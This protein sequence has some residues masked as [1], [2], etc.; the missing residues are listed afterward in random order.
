VDEVF[1]H[2]GCKVTTNGSWRRICRV[3]LSHHGAHDAEHIIWAFND[4]GKQGA[5]GQK[6]NE[7]TEKWALS[8]FFVVGRSQITASET[9][10]GSGK[11]QTLSLEA[12]NN[13]TNQATL[14]T[15]RLY[16]DESTVHEAKPYQ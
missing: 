8:V 6:V 14:N 12:A 5:A 9:K 11:G 7:F 16:K 3:G 10:V 1:A 2:L 13:F 15:I 4:H